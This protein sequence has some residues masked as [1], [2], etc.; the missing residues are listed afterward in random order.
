MWWSVRPHLSFGTV[1]VR[2]LRRAG[3]GGGVRGARR[4]DRRLRARRPPATSTRA[5]RSPIPPPRL[6]EENMWRAIRRGLDGELIDLETASRCSR[7]DAIE[8]L[9]PGRRRSR[10]A[11]HRPDVPGAQRRP[12]PAAA[13]RRGRHA[14]EVF[15]E[16][17]GETRTTYAGC[18]G[19]GR[20]AVTRCR[21]TERG[22]S[23]V[24]EQD[25]GRQ[26]TEEELRA[27][28]EAELKRVTVDD[29]SSRRSS[30]CVNLGGRKAGLAPGTEDERDLDQVRAGDR[31]G[32]RAA[33]AR[34]A[35]SSGRR[36]TA[37]RRALAAADGL[38]AAARRPAPAPRRAA[39]G[40]PR[41]RPGRLRRRGERATSPAARAPR[42][43]RPALGSGAVGVDVRVTA[44]R[45]RALPDRGARLGVLARAHA[46]RDNQTAEDLP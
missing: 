1:E 37:P 3:D 29:V 23:A 16:A 46:S 21:L 41:R 35:R 24:S 39:P 2:D 6:I 33:A 36:R 15:A 27:A 10:R 34:R 14:Q 42:R 9:A 4:A 28:Y 32:P 31:G 43:H 17:V 44:R 30:R 13:D 22:P 8:R 45:L 12:A 38:R 26:P 40:G 18:L 11:R 19:D 7:R 20:A 25:P 5:S